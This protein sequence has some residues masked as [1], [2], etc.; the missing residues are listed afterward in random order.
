ML[1]L[2]QPAAPVAPDALSLEL[3][4]QTLLSANRSDY[5]L[6]GQTF[7]DPD[8]LEKLIGTAERMTYEAPINAKIGANGSI[9]PEVPGYK[10]NREA[11]AERFYAYF[12]GSGPVRSELSRIVIYP[13]VDS[14]LLAHIRQKPI[15]HYVTYYNTRNKNRSH[16]LALAAKTI[17]NYVV[18]PGELFSFNQVVGRRTEERGY[19]R[20]PIIVRGE[21]A[22]GIGG[23]ICQVSSTLFNA[24]D[25]AGLHIIQ[26][27][28]HSR[29]VPYVPPGRDATVSW[30]GP[31]FS[32]RN[33]YNQPILIRA[34]AGGGAMSVSI[35]SS[36]SIEHKPR[37][38]PRT[39]KRL[40]P[41]EEAVDTRSD[42]DATP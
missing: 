19:V 11:L 35:Y 28:S 12:Y 3:Q 10:L 39:S 9:I 8:K 4:G 41:E 42:G 38:V 20:A 25:R 29:N 30:G 31:D 33:P 1:L 37:A 14:E 13:R 17:D 32:F 5:S 6:P 34:F 15:G 26:R 18:F 40:P 24:T 21:L 27:Y 23:G 7:V 22:E 2:Q 36:D 16:N